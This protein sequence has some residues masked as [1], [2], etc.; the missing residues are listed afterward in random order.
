MLTSHNSS[1][2]GNGIK[3]PTAWPLYG[4]A[5]T[6]DEEFVVACGTGGL[7]SLSP[8][9]VS[10]VLH[11]INTDRLVTYAHTYAHIRSHTLTYAP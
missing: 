3:S 10:R 7:L 9:D 6:Q 8:D 2:L 11:T 1:Q 5:Q 4:L